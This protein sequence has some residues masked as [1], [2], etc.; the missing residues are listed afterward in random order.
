MSLLQAL[1]LGLVEGVTEYLPVSSTGHLILAQRVLGIAEGEAADAYAICIQAGAI[2][3]VLG[4]YRHRVVQMLR[5]LVGRDTAGFRL[6]VNVIAAFLPA[7]VVGITLGDAIKAHLFGLWPVVAAWAAGGVAILA[8]DGRMRRPGG[9][10]IESVD[11]RIA[12][13]VGA[14]QCLAMW[15]GT[16]RSLATIL[17]GV[18]AGLSLPAAVEFSVLL[19]LVTLGAA[20]AHDAKDHGRVMVETFGAL[21]LA[22]GFLA[23]TV[24][25]AASVKWLVRWLQAHGMAVFAGWRLVLALVVGGLLASGLWAPVAAP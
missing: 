2:L 18:L 23:A 4:L 15:P 20:T 16:S 3:A 14:V 10:P 1:I 12:L 5:G 8:L 22:V 17:G 9:R 24:A 11:L 7:A 21:P 13:T 25:A 19:G 6:G